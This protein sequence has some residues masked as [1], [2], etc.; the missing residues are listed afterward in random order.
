MHSYPKWNL[1]EPD[2][3]RENNVAQQAQWDE[4]IK[5][6]N[7]GEVIEIDEAMFDYWLEVLPP[8][9]MGRAVTVAGQTRRLSFGFAE[10]YDYI[11]AF[12]RDG[13][14]FFCART[15]EMNHG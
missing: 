3:W 10:G 15:E 8:I 4:F 11:T 6:M 12:W 13:G 5:A 1:A 14:R 2:L 9:Y 7:S